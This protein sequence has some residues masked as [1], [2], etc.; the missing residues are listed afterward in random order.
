VLSDSR[1][2]LGALTDV[3]RCDPLG[4]R[5]PGATDAELAVMQ[6]GCYLLWYLLFLL[7]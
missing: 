1:D 6:V 5:L 4:H 2:Y 7:R 3:E